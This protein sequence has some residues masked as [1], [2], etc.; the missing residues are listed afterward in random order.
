MNSNQYL[1]TTPDLLE[2][3]QANLREFSARI[4]LKVPKATVHKSPSRKLILKK[5][6]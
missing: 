3:T 1:S 6:Q 4:I 5:N 2:C